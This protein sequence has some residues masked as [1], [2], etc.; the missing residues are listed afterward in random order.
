MAVVRRMEVPMRRTLLLAAALVAIPLVAAAQEA[1]APTPEQLVDIRQSKMGRGGGAV[2]ALKKGLDSGAELSTLTPQ[3][4]WLVQ[5]A[6]ELPTLFPEGSDVAG[7][8][9]RP[10]VWTDRA[11]FE[12]AA[13]RFRTATRALAAASA[14]ADRAA[15]LAAWT[16]VR[17]NCAS[18]HAGYKN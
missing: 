17:A 5:W 10:E 12:A 14:G 6:D 11:G 2:A 16:E 13:E 18:C 9:S 15:F 3:A 8:D 7:T 1:A 4:E